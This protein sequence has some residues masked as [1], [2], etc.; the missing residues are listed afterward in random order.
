MT[1]LLRYIVEFRNMCIWQLAVNAW[2]MVNPPKTHNMCSRVSMPCRNSVAAGCWFWHHFERLRCCLIFL[3]K[4]CSVD[5][6]EQ[7]LHEAYKLIDIED[8]L[9]TVSFKFTVFPDLHCSIAWSTKDSISAIG[10]AMTVLKARSCCEIFEG[11]MK[12][13]GG[14]PGA[15]QLPSCSTPADC[16]ARQARREGAGGLG[17]GNTGMRRLQCFFWRSKQ[18]RCMSILRAVQWHHFWDFRRSK[19]C[20]GIVQNGAFTIWNLAGISSNVQ[21]YSV[22]LT[23]QP[24]QFG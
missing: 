6:V 18:C 4:E 1:R 22:K 7:L 14:L 16:T 12:G 10:K 5:L 17:W 11:E 19:H 8:R 3:R 13:M 9:H 15:A 21:A 20:R 24:L 23:F 2:S